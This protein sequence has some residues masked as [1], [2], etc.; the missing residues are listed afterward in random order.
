MANEQAYRLI[1]EQ[2]PI[3]LQ[4]EE[5][6]PNGIQVGITA[7][8][9]YVASVYV[10]P[11][12][13][14]SDVMLDATHEMRNGSDALVL[15]FDNQGTAHQL[16]NDLTLALETDGNRVELGSEQLQGVTGEIVLAQHQREFVLPWPEAL[17][18]GDVEASFDISGD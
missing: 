6:T 3:N 8:Y 11:R 17:P 2:L 5:A 16:L 14:A 9:R 15:S 4:T 18:I 12:E 10:T 13:A 1:T 7:L